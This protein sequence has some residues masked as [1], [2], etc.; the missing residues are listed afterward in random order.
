MSKERQLGVVLGLVAVLA[1]CATSAPGP[2]QREGA[3]GAAEACFRV[4]QV[5]SISPLHERF[6]FVESR[7]HE[8][9]LLT[10]DG[11]NPGVR[12]ATGFAIADDFSRVCA[13]SGASLL[14]LDGGREVRARIIG[15]EAVASRDEAERLVR[16]RTGG[17]RE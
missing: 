2:G 13:D 11:F 8:R 12:F 3:L 4:R 14:Y 10:L 6:V 7:R 5:E 16:E 15:I 17:R 1:S 9:Y